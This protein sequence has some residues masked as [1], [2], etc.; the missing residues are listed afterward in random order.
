MRQL[1]RLVGFA[2][3]VFWG[4]WASPLPYAER[5]H[6][7]VGRPV[8]VGAEPVAAPTNEQVEALLAQFIRE[9]EALFERHKGAVPGY[10]GVKL[11]VL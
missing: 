5:V 7:V 6:T 2:P 11:V 9:M 3:M 4:R 8:N 10:A 1:S